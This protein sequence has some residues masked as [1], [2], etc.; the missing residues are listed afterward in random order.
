MKKIIAFMMAAV[1][2]FTMVACSGGDSG[3]TTSGSETT[4]E[5]SSASGEIYF[6]VPADVTSLDPHVQ[7]DSYS[8][9]VVKM[10]YSTLFV[11]D[12]NNT[13]APS[14]VDTYEVSEDQL[15]WTFNLKKGVKFQNG[16]E[17]TA[18]DVEASFNRALPED[19]GF[20]STSMMSPIESVTAQDDYTVII[21]TKEPYG[22]LLSMLCN[23]NT[24]I[25]DADYIE[26]YGRDLAV[27]P[28]STNGTGPF[29]LVSWS[30]DEELV[31]EANPDYFGDKA[32]VQTIHYM[33]IPEASS[34]VIAL[35][36]GEVDMIH[37]V[38]SEEVSR[39][40]EMEGISVIK[41][42]GVGQ[43]LFRFG[44][45]D[46]IMSNSKVRQAISYAIDRD[47][48]RQALFAEVSTDSVGP[49]APVI[50]GSYDYG[51]IK[52]DV[53]KAKELLKEA[54]Y[55]NGFD[56]KIVTTTQYDKGSELAEML[57]AQL[58]EVGI[59]AQI[60]VLEWSVFLPMISGMTADEFDAPLF[61]MGAG[62][63]MVDADGGYRDLYTTTPDG[64]ND[65]NYG[66]YSNA[67]FDEYVDQGMK[68]TDPEK[69]KEIYQKAG[70][71]LYLDDPAG[72][73]L[74]DQ[75]NVFAYNQD[76]IDGLRIDALGC[77]WFDQ[78]T[79]K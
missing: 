63:S 15:S 42:T 23:Y 27:D 77:V 39:L 52:Q 45:N 58:K 78:A 50:F 56:T 59:N 43:R 12:E 28:E 16:K 54:G 7:N 40:E 48:I 70:Q 24:A 11:F 2:A 34:R 9:E 20:I 22:P 49:L 46:E 1:M 69:R 62:T 19:S 67:E 66:F 5:E 4:G 55:E 64:K 10:I 65:R 35:E 68:E 44:C 41:E 36:N 17:L 32:K 61:I 72:I 74:Y 47:A 26:Q 53:E 21:K 30:K 38:P 33:V 6:G 79:V 31:I 25:M 51:P 18:K 29:K 73:W 75:Y 76:K 37:K 13:P 3:S 57:S 8:E 60:E 71:I 14:L